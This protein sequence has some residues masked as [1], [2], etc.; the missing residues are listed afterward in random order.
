MEQ[1]KFQQ[2]LIAFKTIFRK[3]IVRFMR[4]WPQTL[5]PSA[6]TMALYF[7]IFGNFIGSQIDNIQGFTYMQFIVPGLVMMSVITNA[8]TNTVSSFFGNKFQKSIEELLVS[9]TSNVTI[10]LGYVA[11]GVARGLIV[12]AV[13][14][15][16]SLFFTKI[17]IHNLALVILFVFLTSVLFALAG[18]INGILSKKFDDIAIIPTFVLTPLTYLGGVFYSIALLPEIW[19]TVSKANPILYLVNGFR[20]GFLGISDI[21]VNFAL[22]MAVVFIIILFMANLRLMNKGIGLKE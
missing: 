11:G 17:I 13:V 20:F 10:I 8:Y 15:G 3:E 21:N 7:V 16:V 18:L 6:I 2:N 22:V 14:L 5:L 9:P 1:S 19:Q 12:G 4:I